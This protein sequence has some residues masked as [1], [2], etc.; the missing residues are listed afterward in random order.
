[1]IGLA[2]VVC[3]VVFGALILSVRKVP[4]TAGESGNDRT[5]A[6]VRPVRTRWLWWLAW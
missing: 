6:R 1:M 3:I 5:A 4:G 2:T